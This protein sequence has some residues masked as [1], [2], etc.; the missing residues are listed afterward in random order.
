MTTTISPRSFSF[1]IVENRKSLFWY[2]DTSGVPVKS[3]NIYV[4]DEKGESAR[5]IETLSPDTRLYRV[6]DK[7]L[8]DFFLIEAVYSNGETNFQCLPNHSTPPLVPTD[9]GIPEMNSES[10]KQKYP[11]WFLALSE[12]E[13]QSLLEQNYFNTWLKTTPMLDSDPRNVFKDNPSCPPDTFVWRDDFNVL[14]H[15]DELGKSPEFVFE[16]G[17]T[18]AAPVSGKMNM[19]Q[20]PSEGSLSSFSYYSHIASNYS[21]FDDDTG[22]G[23]IYISRAPGGVIVSLTYDGG[24]QAT[25]EREAEVAYMSGVHTKYIL[26]ALKRTKASPCPVAFIQNKNYKSDSINYNNFR[27]ENGDVLIIFSA[28][29]KQTIGEK[30]TTTENILKLTNLK[31]GVVDYFNTAPNVRKNGLGQKYSI[32][33]ISP[34][35]ETLNVTKWYMNGFETDLDGSRIEIM[36]SDYACDSLL[37]IEPKYI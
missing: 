32:E 31:T 23:Y 29:P 5:L 28:L 3:Y 16:T 10:G 11:L 2:Q 36:L 14:F 24:N 1:C 25:F 34:Q 12:P 17:L 33:V 27:P 7:D 19:I 22:Y 9:A 37:I 26:G 4:C 21:K 8:G 35:L 15:G 18:S 30:P 13:Q 6:K 20:A